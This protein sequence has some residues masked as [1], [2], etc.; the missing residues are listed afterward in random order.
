MGSGAETAC[1][2][3]SYPAS[4]HLPTVLAIAWKQTA[5]MDTKR[6]AFLD[7]L[8]SA[9]DAGD[10]QAAAILPMF[11]HWLIEIARDPEA[12]K[13]ERGSAGYT[14]RMFALRALDEAA[15]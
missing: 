3:F 1:E 11:R 4:S 2:H 8:T 10:R 15:G 9:I 13:H 7:Q 6:A 12:A 14:A 5:G